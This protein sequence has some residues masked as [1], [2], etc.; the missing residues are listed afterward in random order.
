LDPFDEHGDKEIWNALHRVHCS[1]YIQSLPKKLESEV[2][3][4]TLSSFFF[5]HTNRLYPDGNNL[6]VG[7]RQLMCIARALLRNSK[8][9][10]MD[11]ATASVDTETGETL[12]VIVNYLTESVADSVIQK[13]VR[14]EFRDRTV[15]TVAHR[16]NTIMDS[17]KIIVMGD[18]K[19]VEF[20]SPSDLLKS[21]GAF[22][23][24]TQSTGRSPSSLDIS[25]SS[26]G[27]DS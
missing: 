22:W 10:V 8:I 11:E 17:D 26:N 6:S 19:V 23:E 15:L 9:F 27:T 7:Q 2:Q 3:D 5:L 14:T 21:K 16:L 24:L 12:I 20:S 18:G 4:S 13:T 25:S 1:E